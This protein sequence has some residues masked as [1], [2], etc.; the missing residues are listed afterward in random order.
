MAFTTNYSELKGDGLLPVG[1]YEVII[2][3]AG[4]TVSA[5]GTV[6]INLA[7]VIR[8]DVD[9][10]YKDK[11]LWDSL[12]KKKEP[13]AADK[14]CDGY[15]SKRIQMISRAVGFLD[16]QHFA[17]LEDWCE[18]LAGRIALVEIEHD[19]YEGK[20]KARVKWYNET[21]HEDCYHQWEGEEEEE[22]YETDVKP[23]TS[24]ATVVDDDDLPF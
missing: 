15:S 12:F 22:E 24:K 9:Q 2:K 8:N 23:A 20:T 18:A 6:Y 5:G 16:G 13:T 14:S 19:E 21:K 1:K 10:P 3:Y 17:S 7:M 11:F 4:E